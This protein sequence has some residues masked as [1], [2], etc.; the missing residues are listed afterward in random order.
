MAKT[1]TTYLVNTM[2]SV[3]LYRITWKKALR[4][5]LFVSYCFHYTVL[6][7]NVRTQKYKLK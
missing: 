4:F 3:G 7:I 5:V 2:V 6:Y 1:N